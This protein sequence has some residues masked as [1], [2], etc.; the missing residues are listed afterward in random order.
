MQSVTGEDLIGTPVTRKPENS[1][2]Y[3]RNKTRNWQ[4]AYHEPIPG[5]FIQYRFPVCLSASVSSFTANARYSA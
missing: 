1:K 4:C 5:C 3:N 2:T